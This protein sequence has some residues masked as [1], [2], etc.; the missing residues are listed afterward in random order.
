MPYSYQLL[1]YYY[2]ATILRYFFQF[3]IKSNENP[4]MLC[5]IKIKNKLQ[6]HKI[7]FGLIFVRIKISNG[8]NFKNCVVFVI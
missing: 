3:Q 4:K 5:E 8:G 7:D 6:N 2:N 1:E